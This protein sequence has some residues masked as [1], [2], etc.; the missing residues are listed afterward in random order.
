MIRRSPRSTRTDTLFP[1]TTLFRSPERRAASVTDAIPY[2][3]RRRISEPCARAAPDCRQTDRAAWRPCVAARFRLAAVGR[4][5]AASARRQRRRQD[6]AA[7]NA[8]RPA[9][10][11]WRQG[12]LHTG[13]VTAALARPD[14]KRVVS[15]KSVAG[16]VDTGGRRNI[17]KKK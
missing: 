6:L 8:R 9:S 4:R 1:Y 14:R 13:R 10:R 5:I 15:G 7:R 3:V 17:K 16:R 12:E 11:R 2:T